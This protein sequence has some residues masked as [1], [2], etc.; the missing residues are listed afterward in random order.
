MITLLLWVIVL[1]LIAY[2]VNSMGIPEPFRKVVF[3]VL[4]LILIVVI[5]RAAGLAGDLR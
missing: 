5:V 4:C 3:V 2:V 1:G